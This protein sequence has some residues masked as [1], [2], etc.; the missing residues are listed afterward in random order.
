MVPISVS[1][2][3]DARLVIHTHPLFGLMISFKKDA[4]FSTSSNVSLLNNLMY[5]LKMAHSVIPVLDRQFIIKRNMATNLSNWID[6]SIKVNIVMVCSLM[7]GRNPFIGQHCNSIC[8]L[9]SR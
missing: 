7:F 4:P 8:F 3:S 2:V 5:N 6:L 9:F 1:E